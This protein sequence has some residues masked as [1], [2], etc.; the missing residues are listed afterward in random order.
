MTLSMTCQSGLISHLHSSIMVELQDTTPI[1]TNI[2]QDYQVVVNSTHKSTSQGIHSNSS[3]KAVNLAE[4]VI[5]NQ[6]Q[7][8]QPKKDNGKIRAQG[9]LSLPTVVGLCKKSSDKDPSSTNSKQL[10]VCQ[11]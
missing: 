9:R 1:P 10:A 2:D 11:E 8:K 3:L 4:S 5:L 7:S 6:K